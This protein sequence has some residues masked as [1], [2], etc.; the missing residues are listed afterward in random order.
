MDSQSVSAKFLTSTTKFRFTIIIIILSLLVDLCFLKWPIIFFVEDMC[1]YVPYIHTL[2]VIGFGGQWVS[3]S[4]NSLC[5]ACSMTK[6][7]MIK[8]VYKV[9]EDTENF[10]GLRW[11]SILDTVCI[12]CRCDSFNHCHG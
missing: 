6:Y 5:S 3:I 7:A 11:T 4:M 12:T 2:S 9:D 1:R 8:N 10:M